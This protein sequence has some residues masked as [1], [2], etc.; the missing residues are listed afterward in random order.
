MAKSGAKVWQASVFR[1]LLMYLYKAMQHA[2]VCVCCRAI[3]FELAT[4]KKHP[5]TC[6]YISTS[7]E[8]FGYAN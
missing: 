7:Q 1:L 6:L 4:I 5:L 2:A 8:L 3:T